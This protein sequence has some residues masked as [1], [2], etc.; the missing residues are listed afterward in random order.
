MNITFINPKRADIHAQ[1]AL[2]KPAF[3]GLELAKQEYQFC[4]DAVRSKRAGLYQIKGRGVN[5]RFVGIVTDDNDYLILALTG[6]GLVAAAQPIIDAVSGQGYRAVKFHTVKSGMTRI[7]RGFGFV[8]EVTASDTVLTLD[9][10][11]N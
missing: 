6:R 10:G 8:G 5:A 4:C 7:L 11:G 9:L 1:L 3:N 2:L